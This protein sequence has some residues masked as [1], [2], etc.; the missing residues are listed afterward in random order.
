MK[1]KE[2]NQDE[3]KERLQKVLAH[4]GV[5][6]RREC[7]KL[8]AAGR[9]TV[10]GKIVRELGTKVDPASDDV[11]VD[12]EPVRAP[13][14]PVT[15]LVM[16]PKGYICTVHDERGRP[17]V[18]E[19]L[20][21]TDR[22]LY[23]VGR[24]DEDSEGLLLLTDDGSL[25]NLVTHPSHGVEKT[26][27]LRIRGR[28]EG[29]EVTRVES[30]VWLSDGKTGSS[31]IRI[32]KR[33]RDVSRL[34]VTI[35]E[36]RNRELRRTFAKLGHPVLSLRRIRIG[37]LSSRGL[38][39]GTWRKLTLKELRDLKAA[40]IADSGIQDSPQRHKEHRGSKT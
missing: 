40:A 14:H 6:S 38:K 39:L 18:M 9:V 11:R 3:T 1:S 2:Q 25:A 21:P 23:P 22:R 35:T 37:P 24:L 26:Y 30:G 5:A 16:K 19:L 32:K 8:I 17:T 29:A 31:R 20:P 36:G 10:N 12:T 7:E 15:Y 4:A 28:I 34:E 13:N 27:E 33:G